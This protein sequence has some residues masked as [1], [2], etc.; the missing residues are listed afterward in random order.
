MVT[1]VNQTYFGDC[2]PIT[3]NIESLRCIPETNLMLYVNDTP[4]KKKKPFEHGEYSILS[5]QVY[6]HFFVCSYAVNYQRK[7]IE[8]NVFYLFSI[9]IFEVK[10]V[11]L[12]Q[13]VKDFRDRLWEDSGRVQESMR[14]PWNWIHG[15]GTLCLNQP[16]SI[17][18]PFS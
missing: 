13:V 18:C 3:T 12:K 4:I 8:C 17:P 9:P 16:L 14:D 11:L 5:Q 2:F 1:D 7:N 15:A 6:S 10:Q